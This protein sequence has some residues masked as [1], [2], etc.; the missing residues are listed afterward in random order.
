MSPLKI[1]H[2]W[3]IYIIYIDFCMY[4]I[5]TSITAILLC[6]IYIYVFNTQLSHFY[7]SVFANN[8]HQYL[9]LCWWRCQKPHTW[10]PV[11]ILLRVE[12]VGHTV[13]HVLRLKRESAKW[14]DEKQLGLPIRICGEASTVGGRNTVL[15]IVG[16]SPMHVAGCSGHREAITIYTLYLSPHCSRMMSLEKKEKYHIHQCSLLL[17]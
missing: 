8:L 3:V 7:S 14:W 9:C 6:L 11:T 10:H 15:L 13:M 5:Y 12:S 16:H 2:Y 1:K 17:L 4:Y